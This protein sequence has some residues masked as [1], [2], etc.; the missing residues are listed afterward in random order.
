MN[1]PARFFA[2]MTAALQIACAATITPPPEPTA[3]R[4]VYFL[5]HGRH[6]SLVLTRDDDRMVRYAYGDWRWYVEMETGFFR[7][8]PT[9]FSNTP[10]ALGRRELSGPSRADRVR[11][12]I[13]VVIAALHDFRAEAGRVDMLIAELDALF[14]SERET[15][16]YNP[17]YDLEFVRHPVPY[18]LGHNSNHLVGDW[19][20]QLGFR[21][22][23]NPKFGRWRVED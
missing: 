19:L 17:D 4:L 20:Q 1:G 11:G 15:L 16:R 14:E 13:P 3:P 5:D 23:G 21:V 7:V 8:F 6:A 22:R 2:A 12:Q 18:R 10:A 9:L